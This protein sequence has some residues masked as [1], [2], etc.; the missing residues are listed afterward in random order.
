MTYDMTHS[1]PRRESRRQAL[2]CRHKMQSFAQMSLGMPQDTKLTN[3]R[4][5]WRRL[6]SRHRRNIP[7]IYSRCASGCPTKRH[8][9]TDAESRD[10]YCRN[11]DFNSKSSHKE[12]RDAIRH[13][14]NKPT[15]S[16]E[17]RTNDSTC[18]HELSKGT[19]Q[20]AGKSTPSVA[21][22]VV[23]KPTQIHDPRET[24]TSH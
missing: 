5:A 15:S 10:T 2:R 24:T 6:M 7:Y 13:D 1:N 17:T 14:T 20:D 23:A 4:R 3:R 22:P 21:T 12:H 16:V 11:A 18:V 8:Y 19:R 9:R